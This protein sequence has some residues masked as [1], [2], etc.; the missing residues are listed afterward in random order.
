MADN[1]I[2]DEDIRDIAQAY[3]LD[4]V[5]DALRNMGITLDWS[6]SSVAA[7]EYVLDRLCKTARVEKPSPEKVEVVAKIFGSYIGEVFIRNHGGSWGWVSVTGEPIPGI[8]SANGGH[9]FWPWARTLKRLREGA[10]ENVWH[11]YLH[12]TDRLSSI[13]TFE[14]DPKR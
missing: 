3:A 7:V 9:M 5:D 14:P 4:A 13:G 10:E 1:F 8:R 2:A 11:Y 12:L 6:E